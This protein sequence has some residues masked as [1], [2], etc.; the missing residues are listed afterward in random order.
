MDIIERIK[1]GYYDHPLPSRPSQ[2][3]PPEIAAC[4]ETD[5]AVALARRHALYEQFRTDTIEY[6]GLKGHPKARK[7]FELAEED[8]DSDKEGIIFHLDRLSDLL[9]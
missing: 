1:A 5:K 4:Y 6:C 7:A 9:K 8:G 3:T 2:H